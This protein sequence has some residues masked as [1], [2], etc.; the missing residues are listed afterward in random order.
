MTDAECL[1]RAHQCE[2][3]S[4]IV[5]DPELRTEWVMLS[6][7]WQFL[8]SQRSQAEPEDELTFE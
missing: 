4:K 3:R 7:E 6:I 5:R 2:N 1:T 8:A